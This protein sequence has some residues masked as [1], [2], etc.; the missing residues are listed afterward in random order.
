MDSSHK[1]GMRSHC[2]LCVK[3]A[4]ALFYST[5]KEEYSKR[6]SV[7]YVEHQDS[8]LLKVKEWSVLHKSE[9]SKYDL[10]YY[11]TNRDKKREVSIK[12]AK[13][14]PTKRKQQHA[15]RRALKNGATLVPLDDNYWNMLI[16]FY[17]SVCMFPNCTSTLVTLDHIVPLTK[18]GEH[19]IDNF[20][21]LCSFHNT[22][23]GN[24]N[25]IDYRPYPRMEL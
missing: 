3:T 19:S 10:A 14:N 15:K 7:Y 1:D 17:G 21:L 13:D 22:S 23:K 20:Q 5:H 16:E 24:R 6:H 25:S 12:W 8:I 4:Q 2:K 18:H 11:S 9:K